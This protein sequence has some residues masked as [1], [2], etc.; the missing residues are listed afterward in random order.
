MNVEQLTRE[1]DELIRRTMLH[2]E[3]AS[4]LLLTVCIAVLIGVALMVWSEHR[5]KVRRIRAETEWF[6][7]ATISAQYEDNHNACPDEVYDETS[8]QVFYRM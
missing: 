2:N 5:E 7:Q 6:Q 1:T 3:I 8:N 4:F